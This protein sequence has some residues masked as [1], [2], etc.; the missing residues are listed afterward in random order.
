M[1]QQEEG[2]DKTQILRG[3]PEAPVVLAELPT[4]DR[5]DLSREGISTAQHPASK[6]S[7]MEDTIPNVPMRRTIKNSTLS[8][9]T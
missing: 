6:H 1:H 4:L 7:K 5:P 3:N 9:T 8:W 2:E